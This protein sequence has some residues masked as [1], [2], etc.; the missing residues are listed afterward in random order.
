MSSCTN[1]NVEMIH[2][3]K[4]NSLVTLEH[5]SFS[6]PQPYRQCLLTENEFE[7]PTGMIVQE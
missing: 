1:V 6:D 3:R 5:S 4:P 2:N 7:S